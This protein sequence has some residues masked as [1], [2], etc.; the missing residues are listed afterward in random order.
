MSGLRLPLKKQSARTPASYWLTAPAFVENS[1]ALLLHRPRAVTVYAIHARAHMA[2]NY[3][4]H[5]TVCGRKNITFL[6]EPPENC[7]LC[8]T[9]ERNAVESGLPSTY[10]IV[11]RHVHLGRLRAIKTCCAQQR[12]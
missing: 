11:G 3:W 4:C 10:E 6:D 2:V 5:N 9:C 8:E 7:L 1:R 12:Q